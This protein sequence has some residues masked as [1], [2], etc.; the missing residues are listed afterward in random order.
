MQW[1]AQMNY[2]GYSTSNLLFPFFFFFFFF[3]FLTFL[4]ATGEKL[5]GQIEREE[6]F[7][8]KTKQDAL[9]KGSWWN[10]V[11]WDEIRYNFVQYLQTLKEHC[12]NLFFG[13]T[14]A[15]VCL[16]YL[17]LW[18]SNVCFA[19]R[20]IIEKT[21]N[22]KKLCLKSISDIYE[23]DRVTGAVAG[24]VAWY[25]KR[26]REGGFRPTGEWVWVERGL[27]RLDSR[28]ITRL[29]NKKGQARQVQWLSRTA[30]TVVC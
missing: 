7:S 8:A 17:E 19:S 18:V 29:L 4:P 14:I 24:A 30:R 5:K 10:E 9:I 22:R 6:K 2:K 1:K 23:R 3:Y 26:G 20:R 15:S 21:E 16:R 25:S 11:R 28:I 13:R 12:R 27:Y